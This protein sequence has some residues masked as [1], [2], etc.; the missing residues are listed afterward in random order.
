MTHKGD[1]P[2]SG[3]FLLNSSRFDFTHQGT[4]E[5]DVDQSDFRNTNLQPFHGDPLWNSKRMG[6]SLAPFAFWEPGSAC[7]EVGISPVQVSQDLLQGLRITV[8]E[9]GEIGV[10]FESGQLFG[11]LKIGEGLAGG[12]IMLFAPL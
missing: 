9:E 4:V 5:T 7:K 11:H 8:F 3:R 2:V 6:S 1:L 12:L 10:L